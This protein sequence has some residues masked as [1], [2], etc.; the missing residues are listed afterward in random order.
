MKTALAVL[1]WLAASIL[2]SEL[3]GYLLHRLLH[4]GTI[5]FL[6]RS[7]MRHHLLLYGPLHSQRPGSSYHDATTDSISL[8]NIGLEWLMP[9][10][11]LLALS[12]TL[13]HFLRVSVTYQSIFVAG[14]LAW[15]FLMFSYLHDRMHI[16]DFWMERNPWLN[17]W[18]VSAREAHDIHHW[19]LNDQGLMDKNFGIALFFFDRVFGTWT[20]QW[21]SFNRRG[22]TQ[23]LRRFSDVLEPPQPRGSVGAPFNPVVRLSG[24][25]SDR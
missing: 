3:L 6:S 1:S 8:G 19:A 9:G 2:A 13:L 23:A 16:A 7:H 14:S 24:I 12:V 22:Y 15:S 17:R 25:G 10:A 20:P 5:G 4:S 21:P 11:L 18:F